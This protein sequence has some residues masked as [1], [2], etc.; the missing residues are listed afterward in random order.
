MLKIIVFKKM[1]VSERGGSIIL[2][3]R[4]T[5]RVSSRSSRPF[6]LSS[7]LQLITYSLVFPPP[8]PTFMQQKFCIQCRPSLYIFRSLTFYIFSIFTDIEFKVNL[9]ISLLYTPNK[10]L[11]SFCWNLHLTFIQSQSFIFL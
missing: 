10:V 8:Q 3:R 9:F 5:G 4:F 6:F 2:V 11:L 1:F 7:S